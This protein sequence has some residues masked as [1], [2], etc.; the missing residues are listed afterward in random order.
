MHLQLKTKTSPNLQENSTAVL[1]GECSRKFQPD[2]VSRAV[3]RES[4]VDVNGYFSF[5]SLLGS[6][7]RSQILAL[8]SEFTEVCTA[9]NSTAVEL[10]RI[11]HHL[12]FSRKLLCQLCQQLSDLSIHDLNGGSLGLV[13]AKF[14][15]I[16]EAV[17]STNFTSKRR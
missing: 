3:M 1:L 13:I 6:G 2:R 16:F 5:P 10:N 9:H 14:V 12:N 11:M 15:K 7:I 4:A 8:G 17:D